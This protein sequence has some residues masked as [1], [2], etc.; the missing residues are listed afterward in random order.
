MVQAL[1][2]AT[3][4]ELDTPVLCL[5]V[6]QFEQ[7]LQHMASVV[8]AGG[9]AW[10]PHS[11]GHKC[12]SIAWRELG[13]GALGITCA[14]LGEAEAMAAAGIHN[15]LIAN[16]I[17]G[18]HK[19]KRLAALSRWARPIIC[20]DHFVQADAISQACRQLGTTCQ[21]LVDIN[22]GM[23]RTGIR[24]GTDALELGQAI[25]KLPGLKL[26]GIMGYEGHLL[27]LS[28]AEDKRRQVREAISILESTR[29]AYLRSGLCCDIVSAGGTG[30][31]AITAECPAVTEVQAGGG[32]LG[33]PLYI[34]Q[35]G[36]TGCQPA[37]TVLATVVSRPALHRAI[38]D[39]GRKTTNPDLCPPRIK[40]YPDAEIVSMSAEHCTLA[41]GPE[42]QSLKIGDQVEVIVG[43]CDFTTPLHEEFFVFRGNRLEALWPIAGRGRLQ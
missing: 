37:V 39:A 6:E 15:V 4:G 42:S 21:V 14:K 18:P 41:L 13:E 8:A 26:L 2:G 12:P 30:S 38:L 28:E 24:P 11:K 43:Y 9:K 27:R 17:F 19:A 31:V 33:D 25:D 22:I 34:E 29:D 20:C 35:M 36:L 5:D 32:V 40:D 10:R 3:K 23:N 1:I 7:N 16:V